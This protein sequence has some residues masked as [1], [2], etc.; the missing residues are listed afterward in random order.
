METIDVIAE[1]R[2]FFDQP[3]VKL[4]KIVQDRGEYID[5][6]YA[7]MC[8][9]L[10]EVLGIDPYTV[11][12]DGFDVTRPTYRTFMFDL[13]GKRIVRDEHTQKLD[14]MWTADQ[15]RLIHEWWE[16]IPPEFKGDND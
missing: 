6:P 4:N 1:L 12:L 2:K 8:W 14:V 13:N 5:S 16:Y 10:G 7:G 15:K 9:I 3:Y 11:S